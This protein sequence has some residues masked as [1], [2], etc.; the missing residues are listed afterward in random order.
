MNQ[1]VVIV[2]D[3]ALITDNLRDLLELESD[4]EVVTFNDPNKAVE[5]LRENQDVGVVVS[6]FMMPGM[7]GLEFLTAAS[8][9]IPQASLIMLTG[10]ADKENVI[11]AINTINLF[12]YLEKPWDNDNFMLLIKRAAERTDLIGKLQGK[13]A[14]LE[15]MDK[16]KAVFGRVVPEDVMHAYLQDN[17]DFGG[18][19][20]DVSVLLCDIRNFT[21]LS[22]ELGPESTCNVLNV[23]FEAVVDAVTEHGGIVDK[24]MGDA[25]LSLFGAP[26]GPEKYAEAAL[27]AGK[28]IQARLQKLNETAFKDNPLKISMGI[29][30][31]SAVVGL[32]GS[33]KKQEYTAI[34]DVVNLVA[35]LQDLSKIFANKILCDES[36]YLAQNESGR[37][38][39]NQVSEIELK[40][41]DKPIMVYAAEE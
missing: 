33:E 39:L 32:L 38:K 34:G 13:I 30:T 16:M 10:Y 18:K 31:G 8:G 29:T 1:R 41:F 17:M 35:R 3:E 36:T 20:Q 19:V 4:F 24:F 26:A 37:D 12:Q 15:S 23:Y 2:D 27:A 6:D 40:G 21:K 25:V 5:Y 7:N 28:D 11:K 22:S 9:V 14:E